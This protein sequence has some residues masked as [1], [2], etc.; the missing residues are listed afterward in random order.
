MRIATVCLLKLSF[1]RTHFPQSPTG[2][3]DPAKD[4][5]SPQVYAV[6]R[7]DRRTSSGTFGPNRGFRAA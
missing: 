6:A 5:V 1:G 7:V 4:V 2:A 3:A